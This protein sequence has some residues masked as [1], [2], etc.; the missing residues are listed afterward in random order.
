VLGFGFAQ[1]AFG[2]L[3]MRV[4]EMD[5]VVQ[6]QSRQR[7]RFRA[8]ELWPSLAKYVERMVMSFLNSHAARF[9]ARSAVAQKKNVKPE[10]GFAF[11]KS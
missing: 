8:R 7:V 1:S 2:K 5:G 10:S 6:Q 9:S 3:Q 11:F 4:R